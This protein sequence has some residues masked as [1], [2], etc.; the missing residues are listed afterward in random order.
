MCLENK[1]TKSGWLMMTDLRTIVQI[2]NWLY[3]GVTELKGAAF[4][5]LCGAGGGGV[6]TPGRS[7]QKL[8]GT[9]SLG[10][11]SRRGGAEP[12]AHPA[13]L[14]PGRAAR[15]ARNYHSQ[16]AVRVR[17]GSGGGGGGRKGASD[18]FGGGFFLRVCWVRQPRGPR[19][20]TRSR[21]A[22]AAPGLAG[23]SRRLHP[24][25][26]PGAGCRALGAEAAGAAGGSRRVRRG[27]RER[28]SSSTA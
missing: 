17:E 15:P 23:E 9:S 3:R 21:A 22:P 11:A 7:L 25:D 20:R 18:C 10:T 14:R 2:P 28:W 6:G 13:W 19:R 4:V 16:K 1:C 12:R 26:G 5:Q 27:W 8:A 24:R